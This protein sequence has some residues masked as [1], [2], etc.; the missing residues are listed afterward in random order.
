MQGLEVILSA[1]SPQ[2]EEHIAHVM[3][4]AGDKI[5]VWRHYN[6]QGCAKSQRLLQALNP[7]RTD[8]ISLLLL[9]PFEQQCQGLHFLPRLYQ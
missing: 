3:T 9:P 5:L 1:A 7:S 6:W 4:E 2:G 8:E